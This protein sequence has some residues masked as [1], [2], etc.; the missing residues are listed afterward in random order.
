MATLV[1]FLPNGLK[2]A[3][4]VNRDYPA[5]TV[6]RQDPC[7]VQA[8]SDEVSRQ[9]C[10]VRYEAGRYLLE[11]LGSRNGTFLDDRRVEGPAT[12]S[13]GSEIRCG[14]YRLQFFLEDAELGPRTTEMTTDPTQDPLG[15]LEAAL[16]SAGVALATLKERAVEPPQAPTVDHQVV[17]V[18]SMATELDAEAA[19]SAT[20]PPDAG[21]ELVVLLDLREQWG[22]RHLWIH[23]DGRA[24]GM[25]LGPENGGLEG[26]Y[27]LEVSGGAFGRL[28]RAVQGE[29][30]LALGPPGRSSL[31]DESR[32]TIFVQWEDGSR[33]A[34][35]KWAG[36]RVEAF[37]AVNS[38]IMATMRGAMNSAVPLEEA[39]GPTWC[40][41]GLPS[42]ADVMEATE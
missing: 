11:D 8:S 23:R 24:Y 5:V 39:P 10:K 33:S 3:V 29:S 14:T 38:L 20:L 9:H 18:T 35:T 37:D 41:A 15:A 2:Q 7:E 40:P 32:V 16:A 36:E 31:P 30:F 25:L 1:Y 19:I 27:R 42:P 4:F 26:V 12:L 22:G 17:E 28:E 21:V 6:G 34:R 13:H